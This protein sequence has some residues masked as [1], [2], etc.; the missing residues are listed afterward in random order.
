MTLSPVDPAG[1]NTLLSLLRGGKTYVDI[2]GP[3]NNLDY[4]RI[5]KPLIAANP[6][7][8]TWG[9]NWPHV[10][11]IPGRKFTEI[12]PMD[13]VDDG[14]DINRLPTWTSGADQLKLILVENPA[15]L[16]GF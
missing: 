15:R 2:A 4:A 11:R 12:T 1:F 10:A 6:Q 7:R 3:Y 14:R 16:Y 13:Q 9:T 8:I 5:A